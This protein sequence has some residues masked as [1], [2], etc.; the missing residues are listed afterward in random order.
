LRQKDIDRFWSHV[1]RQGPDDCWLWSASKDTAGYGHLRIAGR[2]RKAHRVALE[3]TGVVF[4]A[5]ECSLHKCD[6]PACVNPAHLFVGTKADNAHDRDQKDRHVVGRGNTGKT[7]SPAV[8]AKIS[9][10]VQAAYAEGRGR[11]VT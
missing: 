2:L 9:A 7:H 10:A 5:G 11:W 8:R 1:G 6:T 4:K 3:L